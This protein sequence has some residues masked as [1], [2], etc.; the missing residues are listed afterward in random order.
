MLAEFP[1]ELSKSY[2][3]APLLTAPAFKYLAPP[4]P[5]R[6]LAQLVVVAI[7]RDC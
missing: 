6:T 3:C 4:T 1:D 2:L 7:Y 5:D